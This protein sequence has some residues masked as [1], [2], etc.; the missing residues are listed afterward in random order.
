[1][2]QCLGPYLFFGGV[3]AFYVNKELW[4]FEE[5]GHLLAGW[6]LFYILASRTVAYRLD[7]WATSKYLERMDYYKQLIADDLKDAVDFRKVSFFI[8]QVVQA[9]SRTVH[10]FFSYFVVNLYAGHIKGTDLHWIHFF[11]NES[12]RKLFHTLTYSCFLYFD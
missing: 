8:S 7:K 10:K 5:Q 1:M 4:V 11:N 3:I 9:T 12:G 2:F 6:I